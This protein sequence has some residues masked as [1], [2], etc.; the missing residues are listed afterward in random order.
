MHI[1][2]EVYDTT[3]IGDNVGCTSRVNAVPVHLVTHTVEAWGGACRHGERG[4][5]LTDSV[6]IATCG[7][8]ALVP[9]LANLQ[10]IVAHYVTTFGRRTIGIESI[11]EEG[12]VTPVNVY[13]AAHPTTGVV[14]CGL[15]LIASLG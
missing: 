6:T 11:L 9:C 3:T 13:V 8:V 10:R 4:H 7:A 15:H 2:H 12:V 5:A 14:K 1:E